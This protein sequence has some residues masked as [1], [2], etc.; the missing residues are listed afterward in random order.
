MVVFVVPSQWRFLVVLGQI[1][2]CRVGAMDSGS[3]SASSMASLPRSVMDDT[4]TTCRESEWYHALNHMPAIAEWVSQW[5]GP[6]YLHMLDMFSASGMCQIIWTHHGYRAVNTDILLGEE[7]DITTKPGFMNTLVIA[8]ALLPYA[9]L[10]AGF[11]CSWWIFLSSGIH[12]RS[13][14]QPWGAVAHPKAR[15]SNLILCKTMALVRA[16]ALRNVWVVCEQPSTSVAR[17]TLVMMDLTVGFSLEIV[18]TW[19]ICFNHLMPKCTHLWG[20]MPTLRMMRRTWRGNSSTPRSHIRK[21]KGGKV[22]GGPRLHESAAYT[23]E[24]AMHLLAAWEVARSF[25][26]D[27]V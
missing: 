7:Y 13:D 25:L 24:F 17:K 21:S 23:A 4:T 16:I 8:L 11:P 2:W 10:M 18:T 22:S 19:V 20:N 6:R 3:A 27:C 1:M 15:L 12:R 5:N 14:V 9:L 26:I